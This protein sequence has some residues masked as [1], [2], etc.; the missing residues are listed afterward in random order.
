MRKQFKSAMILIAGTQARFARMAN[1]TD[2]QISRLVR[3]HGP[4]PTELKRLAKFF[5]PYQLEKF[6]GS[7]V[8][9]EQA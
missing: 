8:G 5:S 7:S 3:G 1:L 2:A 4:G 9:G 6:F